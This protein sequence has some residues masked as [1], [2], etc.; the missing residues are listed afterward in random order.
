MTE[1]EKHL[2][3]VNEVVVLAERMAGAGR[4]WT[5]LTE[6]SERLRRPLSEIIRVFEILGLKPMAWSDP[7]SYRLSDIIEAGTRHEVS[8]RANR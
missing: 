7:S 6:I 1:F 3:L 8:R 4:T 5:S 2:P